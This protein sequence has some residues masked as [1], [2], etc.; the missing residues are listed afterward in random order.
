MG[1]N[2]NIFLL[3]G[4]ILLAIFLLGGSV[5]TDYIGK[6]GWLIAGAVILLLIFGGKKKK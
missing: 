6:F 5:L 2:L 3:G 1:D 4:G